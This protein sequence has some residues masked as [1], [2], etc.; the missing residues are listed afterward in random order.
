MTAV[1]IVLSIIIIVVVF[2]VPHVRGALQHADDTPPQNTHSL[3]LIRIQALPKWLPGIDNLLE[4]SS[5]L[6]QVVGPFTEELEHVHIALT[7]MSVQ[8]C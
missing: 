7:Q 1:G 8:N 3:L 6:S 4:F 2:F 5:P